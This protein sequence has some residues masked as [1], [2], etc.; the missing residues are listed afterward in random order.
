MYKNGFYVFSFLGYS[1]A[2]FSHV[3]TF[4]NL[5]SLNVPIE[6]TM[7]AIE[8]LDQGYE[9]RGSYLKYVLLAGVFYNVK[10][11]WSFIT[12]KSLSKNLSNENKHWCFCCLQDKM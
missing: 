10:N 2:V 3:Q 8:H 5:P 9:A 7:M 4:F 6:F 12:S 1:Q 11:G